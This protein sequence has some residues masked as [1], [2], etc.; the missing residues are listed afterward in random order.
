MSPSELRPKILVVGSGGH[1]KVVIDVLRAEGKYE[2]SGC[3]SNQTDVEEVLGVPLLGD[4]SKMEEIYAS[5][6]KIAIIAIGDNRVRLAL[7]EKVSRLGFEFGNAISPL[8]YLSRDVKVGNGIVM[9]P[10]VVVHPGSEIEDHV[11]LN[12]AATV[13]HD[14]KIGRGCHIAPGCNLAGNVTVEEGAFLGVGT[15]AIP[16]VRVG[17]WGILGAGSVIVGDAPGRTLSMGVPAR[18]KKKL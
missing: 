8:A 7:A 10:R 14:C 13:D 12:T 2:I 1:A 17:A 15:S 3:V 5:G 9:M 11:I 16:G 18:A 6:I 4:D